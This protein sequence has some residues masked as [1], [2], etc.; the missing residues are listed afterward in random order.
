MNAVWRKSSH[1]NGSQPNCV[2][3]A[4]GVDAVAVRDSKNTSGPVLTF[5]ATGWANFLRGRR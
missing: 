5:R 3:V 1:S 2:E 4:L